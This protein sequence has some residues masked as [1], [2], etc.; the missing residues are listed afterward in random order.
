MI[1]GTITNV[2][3][4]SNDPLFIL[5]H[6]FVDYILEMWIRRNH[7][8]FLPPPGS[9]SA[10]K[11]HNYNDVIVPFLPLIECHEL[12]VD[13]RKLGWTYESLNGLD[14]ESKSCVEYKSGNNSAVLY[15]ESSQ[16]QLQ[17]LATAN[18]PNDND[19]TSVRREQQKSILDTDSQVQNALKNNF[20]TVTSKLYS[21]SPQEETE[22]IHH[23][24]FT[25]VYV[26]TFRSEKLVFQ[27]PP[28]CNEVVFQ[29]N[30]ILPKTLTPLGWYRC[31]PQQDQ[32]G[33]TPVQS[34]FKINP[35][36]LYTC[37]LIM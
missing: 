18:H 29:S 11:G 1:D 12:L 35:N 24:H 36:T 2:P 32:S 30:L 13:S 28:N 10:E 6:A 16:I 34:N 23:Q 5:H 27:V 8:E 3:T 7:G 15:P 14:L 9:I 17:S 25:P 19:Q 26:C 20:F 31:F 33:K 21:L 22:G 4:A 37:N